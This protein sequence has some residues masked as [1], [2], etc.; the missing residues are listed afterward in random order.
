M[1][2]DNIPFG[3]RPVLH[4]SGEIKTARV[5]KDA[6]SGGIGKGDLL[7]IEADGNVNRY[8]GGTSEVII[9]VAA[10]AAATAVAATILAYIDPE[11]LFEVQHTASLAST[12]RGGACTV[13]STA[14]NATLGLSKYVIANVGTSAN[15]THIIQVIDRTRRLNSDGTEN[16]WGS[17]VKVLVKL[18]KNNLQGRGTAV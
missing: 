6:S 5:Y 15:A 1:A 14:Y 4:P 16:A 11:I 8:T 18:N 2:N 17:F 12:G 13:T 3:F 10:Q 9:G 7:S